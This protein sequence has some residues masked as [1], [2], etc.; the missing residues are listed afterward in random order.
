MRDISAVV[1]CYAPAPLTQAELARIERIVTASSEADGYDPVADMK[2]T[3]GQ[4]PPARR[5]RYRALG[6]IMSLGFMPWGFPCFAHHRVALNPLAISAGPSAL[7]SSTG[8]QQASFV[9]LG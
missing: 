9:L 5:R 3:L 1:D 4:A 6:F 2:R 8:L 7:M